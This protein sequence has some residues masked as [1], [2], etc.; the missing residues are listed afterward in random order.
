MKTIFFLATMYLFCAGNSKLH[1]AGIHSPRV[2]D[3]VTLAGKWYLQPVLASDTAAGKIPVLQINLSGN[4]FTGN[5]GCN[6]MRGSF[7]KTP[8]SF[9]FNKNIITTKMLCPGYDE[10]A[11]M[12]SL[13][14]A[15]NYKIEKD[16]LVLLF[17]GTELSRWTRNPPKQLKIKKA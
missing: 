11:F 13:L 10:A 5:T 6:N 8:T 1:V 9:S 12:R 15:N 16:V 3:T 17:D 14:Q 2:T 4:S 7:Q